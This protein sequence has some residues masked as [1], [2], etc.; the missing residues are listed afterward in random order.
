MTCSISAVACPPAYDLSSSTLH[1]VHQARCLH[2]LIDPGDTPCNHAIE[3]SQILLLFLG[4]PQLLETTHALVVHSTFELVSFPGAG[5]WL[6]NA[7][8]QLQV[9][10][11]LTVWRSHYSSLGNEVIWIHGGVLVRFI[12]CW[13]IIRMCRLTGGSWRLALPIGLVELVKSIANSIVMPTLIHF[14]QI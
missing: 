9:L 13:L 7:G 11:D 4:S 3:V 5:I 6:L 14:Y 1:E 10:G 2:Y 12:V 8:L